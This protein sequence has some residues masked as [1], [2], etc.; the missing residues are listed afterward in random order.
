V[1]TDR[2][3]HELGSKPLIGDGTNPFS[4]YLAFPNIVLL[5]DPGAGKTHL[6]T[7]FAQLQLGEFRPARSFLNVGTEALRGKDILFI[8]ALD[9]RRSDR[10]DNNATDEI[11]KKLFQV[12]PKQVRISCRA[13]DW[14]GET[15]LVGFKDY[16]DGSGGYVVLNLQPL[17]QTEQVKIL[18]ISGIEDTDEF[19]AH[20]EIK[21]LSELLG[22]PQNLKMLAEVVNKRGW[23]TTRSQLFEQAIE[24]LLTETNK[25]ISQKKQG[26][27][28]AN[29]LLEVAGEVC[30]VRL[31]SDIQAIS[32]AEYDAAEDMPSYRTISSG[33]GEKVIA[34]LGR[35]VFSMGT[36]TETV[37]YAHRV[38]A[39]YLAATWLSSKVRHG[40]PI[41][42]VRALIGVDGR[43][44]TELRGLHAWLAVQL[45]E[46][47][48]VLINA[49]PFGVLTYADAKVLTSTNRKK[50]LGAL[51]TL[52][53]SDP[54]FRDGHW[55][56]SSLAGLAGADMVEDFR[57][58]LKN[59]APNFSLRMLVLDSLAVGQPVPQ[60]FAE[61]LSIVKNTNAFY[62]ERESAVDALI[63]MGDTGIKAVAGAYQD[64]G[65]SG[66]DLR[67][68]ANLFKRLGGTA[69]KA[70]LLPPLLY[71]VL[72]A[73]VKSS[74]DVLYG[75]SSCVPDHDVGRTLD[76]LATSLGAIPDESVWDGV[77]SLEA[78]FNRL[79]FR[80]LDIEKDLEGPRL[81]S[82]LECRKSIANLFGDSRAQEVHTELASYPDTSARAMTAALKELKVE[83]SIW[84]FTHRLRGLGLLFLGDETFLLLVIA[85]MQNSRSVERK[86]HLYNLALN[87]AVHQ[88]GPEASSTFEWLFNFA[89]GDSAL[90]TVRINSCYS[91]IPVW[92]TK[93]AARKK[94]REQSRSD[95]RAKNRTGFEKHVSNIRNGADLSWLGWIAQVYF[96][97]F[98]DVNREATPLE[99]LTS[100]LGVANA[101]TA[102]EGLL[103][104]IRKEKITP[105]NEILRMLGEGKYFQWWY[106][107]I[108]G[109]DL[110]V[111][112]GGR[113]DDLK[114]EF[115][116]AALVI[117]AM[118]TTFI[119]RGNTSSQY[120]HSWKTLILESR[121]ALA[122]DAYS[123][124]ARFDLAR[125][126]QSAFGLHDL[127]HETG[128]QPFRE[129]SAMKL[130][131]E[132][133]NAPN[134]SLKQLIQAVMSGCNSPLF[135]SLAKDV[136]SK[137]LER[138]D[139]L[140]L[141]LA[142][143]YVVAPIEFI[144][145]CDALDESELDALIWALRAVSGYARRSKKHTSKLNNQQLEQILRWVMKQFPRTSYPEGGWSGDENP[146]DATE[147]AL[148][149]IALLSAEPSIAAMQSLERLALEP[150]ASSYLDDIKHAVAQQRVRMIDARY[151]QPSVQQVVRT[152]SNDQPCTIGDL[153]ALML[154][155]L[156]DLNPLIAGTNVDVFKRFW[157]EDSY[158][159]VVNPKNEESCRDYIVE[160]LRTRTIEQKIAIEPEVH[161][162]ADKRA[163]IVAS[164][165][166]MKLVI[167]L[168]RD[169]HSEVWV[170]IQ[171]QLERFY[172]RDPEAQG[173]GIYL[174]LWFGTK[175]TSAIRIPPS[176]YKRPES[177][178]EMQATLQ[179][180][181]PEGK[182]HK[183]GV[184]VLDVSGDI[185]A[186][187]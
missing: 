121:P 52:A 79:L 66:D 2:Y 148:R 102:I 160:L 111:E 151:H 153:H 180:L 98:N 118:C 152:L 179:S 58:I 173:Y 53:D 157:N 80:A 176:P 129:A 45:P 110:Y 62:A 168:K 82:W 84:S 60:L 123:E 115:L 93:D 158:G 12:N 165:P 81:I 109:L 112:Q 15:D 35:R 30:A 40:L 38:I 154:Q 9:E 146:W 56:S 41:G 43:P 140:V 18:R 156:E 19:L 125:S 44:A 101:E 147:F 42:R 48:E 28:S 75:V 24:V 106:A 61:L 86:A 65:S 31:I 39:E 68:K 51:A 26:R 104:L 162:A 57:L 174:V 74:F 46:Y 17:S 113:I 137:G 1:L 50:L 107:I 47:A 169:Y 23:P 27:Y 166:G 133:P 22:N 63:Y 116:S 36:M 33:D 122:A 25:C 6:F 94:E 97:N 186:V 96:A 88:I 142:A 185:P 32:L 8:D 72:T 83:E 34:A 182:R 4:S 78:E 124:L 37:D 183:I 29:E 89:E 64:I 120:I 143:G 7:E 161:M 155:H 138:K 159:K 149:L 95:D 130:L 21:G 128:L 145:Y 55:T 135:V 5:G 91:E 59:P 70:D 14:L 126:S 69:L 131:T 139:A 136:V 132:F 10:G 114:D 164:V 170:A 54:W 163:D 16:F 77:W 127:L 108:A 3:V 49:D 20:A 172:S 167:E 181:I 178:S 119:Y 92:R 171:E 177:A 13:A 99:R 141:W 150:S 11:V 175:R 76:Q 105:M 67:L 117:N 73:K 90:E 71:E 187:A 134:D 184:V 144:S 85:E 87:V 103:A 100:E